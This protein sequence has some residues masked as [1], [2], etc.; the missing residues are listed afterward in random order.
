[1]AVAW[2]IWPF[3][4]SLTALSADSITEA[5]SLLEF[6]KS[7][8]NAESLDSWTPD[9]E[10]CGDN[11]RWVGLLCNK[12]NVF[13][14]QIEQMGLSGNIDVAPLISLPRLRTISIMN[15]S[16]SGE[17]PEFNRLTALKSIYLSGN[18]FSGNIPSDYFETM[19]SLKKAWLS[20]NEFS[21]LIPVSLAT[22]LPNLMELRLEN[23]Q[24]LG[25]IPNFT[26]PTLVDVNLSN[27]KL[28]GEIPPGLSKFDV[29]FFEGNH[30]LCGTKLAT[31]CTQPRNSTPKIE[32][33]GTM[34][35]ANKSKYYI[36]FGTLAVLFIIILI[37]LVFRKKKKKRRRKKKSRASEHDSSD[38]NQIQVTV[39]GSRTSG[40]KHSKSS[41]SSELTNRS[42]TSDLVMVNKEKGVFGL[43]DLM[44]AAAHVLGNT[45]NGTSRP[46]SN[47][48]VGSAYKAVIATGVAVVVKRIT[49]MNQV[50]IEVF[51][52]EI[53]TLGGLR[54]RNILTPLAYH[55]RRD[56]KL[57]V[58]EF[59]PNLSLLHR[60]HSDH[61]EDFQL[62]WPSRFKIIQGIAKGMW[63]LHKEL[64]FLTLPHGNLKSSNIFIGD[65]G[66]PLISEFGLQRL[67]NPDA[68]LQSLVA[69]RSPES[70]RDHG[71]VSSKSDVFS[72][73]VVVL[74][75]LTGKFPSQYAG[76]N[77][78]GGTD[79]VEWIGSAVE[80]GGWMDLLHP[81]VVSAAGDDVATEE[82]IENVLRIGVR[83]TGEDPD[84]RPS[85]TEVIDELT[86]DDSSEDFIT[87][88]T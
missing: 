48:S 24:F 55:F 71:I 65:D 35:D 5:E 15:N 32:I 40:S 81:T 57:L 36:A 78:A 61:G 2:L 14:L 76:L 39:E 66:E 83:C 53:R 60:L 45:G 11:Q 84:R 34:K 46:S 52:K 88:E 75:I 1:M 3:V 62:D 23:N 82:E 73:G 33:D 74:E 6:K 38:D 7:L 22:S 41:S 80:R 59:V 47:G 50:S 85:M 30:G 68:R 13:G 86:V 69:Y 72:F 10:P 20:N 19:A 18:R 54:H 29:R 4:L 21:G 42:I 56:E 8:I 17:I 27:N 12:N 25:I 37:S 64:E 87:I 43:P 26:Q 31:T 63:Y 58:F 70:D 67:I 79:L 49:V 51:D 9:S 44:K 16:F 28:T 77:R